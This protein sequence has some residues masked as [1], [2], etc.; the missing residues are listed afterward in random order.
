[1]G[2]QYLGNYGD[3]DGLSY[4]ITKILQSNE[5]VVRSKS[6]TSMRHEIG[7]GTPVELKMTLNRSGKRL[8]SRSLFSSTGVFAVRASDYGD[9]FER[10]IKG[11]VPDVKGSVGARK[12]ALAKIV[13]QG[14]MMAIDDDDIAGC[15]ILMRQDGHQYTVYLLGENS[16]ST[17]FPLSVPVPP[18]G[19]LNYDQVQRE[20]IR[21]LDDI[22]TP[23]MR[24]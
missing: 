17:K 13:S 23:G 20:M 5:Y 21:V 19:I 6:F 16:L 7:R 22:V 8:G 14:D 3:Y 1:V 9:D 10:D 18:N 2:S 4:F 11:L 12:A 24:D 15:T